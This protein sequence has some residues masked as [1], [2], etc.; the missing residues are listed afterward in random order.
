MILGIIAESSSMDKT[1]ASP[2]GLVTAE[3]VASHLSMAEGTIRN[4]ANRGE[5]PFVKIG[6]ALRFRLS[7]IDA[8]VRSRQAAAA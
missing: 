1:I 4:M 7:E 3:R 6:R 2:E 5:I 8:W